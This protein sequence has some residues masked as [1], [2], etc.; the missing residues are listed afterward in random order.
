MAHLGVLQHLDGG[1]VLVVWAGT[2]ELVQLRD[3]AAGVTFIGCQQVS[4]QRCNLCQ[5][6]TMQR[7]HK[8]G[9]SGKGIG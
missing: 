4:H 1:A 7:Q 8:A 3:E 9:A 2:V 5:T 6:C